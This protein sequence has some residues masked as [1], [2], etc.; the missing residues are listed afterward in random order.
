MLGTDLDIKLIVMLF[1]GYLSLVLQ[2]LNVLH[3]KDFAVRAAH[4]SS[5]TYLQ[6]ID[7]GVFKIT[8]YIH[9]LLKNIHYEKR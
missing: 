5:R 3:I 2:S 8:T 6:L 7:S 9:F 4:V 1:A